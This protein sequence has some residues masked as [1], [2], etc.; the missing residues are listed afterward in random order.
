MEHIE[1]I[2]HH[3]RQTMSD[4]IPTIILIVM[5]EELHPRI[6]KLG[7][8]LKKDYTWLN[9]KDFFNRIKEEWEKDHGEGLDPKII[10]DLGWKQICESMKT[11]KR[12]RASLM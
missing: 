5:K 10:W 11:E 6:H 9:N 1:K 4:H 12:R 8:Y 7:T 3:G 2:D